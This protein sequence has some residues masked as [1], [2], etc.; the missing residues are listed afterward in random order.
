MSILIEQTENELCAE[1]DFWTDFVSRWRE[2]RDE[3]VHQRAFEALDRA[4]SR[5]ESLL[6]DQNRYSENRGDPPI[7]H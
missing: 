2:S 4:E 7:L 1:I 3:P 5:L 6:T